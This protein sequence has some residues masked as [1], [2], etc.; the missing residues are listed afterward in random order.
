MTRFCV[1]VHHAG[2]SFDALRDLAQAAEGLGFD[3]VSLY[4]VLN[5]GALEV[6]TALTGLAVVHPPGWC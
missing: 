3:G 6:W 4:D 5:P 1:R 2:L